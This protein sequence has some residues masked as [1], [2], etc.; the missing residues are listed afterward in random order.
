MREPEN[1]EALGFPSYEEAQQSA[2]KM[3]SSASF[4]ILAIVERATRWPRF[5]SAPWIRVQPQLGLS[6]AIGTTTA[7]FDL[8]AGSPDPRRRVCPLPRDQLAVP[9]ENR[10]RCDDRRDIRKHPPAEALTDHGETPTVVVTQPHPSATEV[11][12]QDAILFPKAFDDVALLPL[13]PAEQRGD[14]EVR[15]KH[16][17]RSRQSDADAVFGR[18]EHASTMPSG[19]VSAAV[20]SPHIGRSSVI[21]IASATRAI[22]S[23]VSRPARAFNRLLS[24]E[25]I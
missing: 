14:D 4:R 9:P 3:G 22:S 18:Y 15:R 2:S 1:V 12:L 13:E 6:A 17:R 7:D 8:H 23:A 19:A 25:R 24:I 20:R 10:V 5:L 11:R 21:A 16:T